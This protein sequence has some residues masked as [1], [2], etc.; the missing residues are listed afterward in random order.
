MLGCLRLTVK[1]AMR[2][3]HALGKRLEAGVAKETL[4]SQ[5]AVE[6]LRDGVRDMLGKHNISPEGS[7]ESDA[8]SLSNCKVYVSITDTIKIRFAY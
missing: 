5:N 2:E 6:I 1:E 4:D 3:L 7:L 8:F